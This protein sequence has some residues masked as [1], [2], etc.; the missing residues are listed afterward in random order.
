MVGDLCEGLGVTGKEDESLSK[1]SPGK[2]V[3]Q[4]SA[5]GASQAQAPTC[6]LV[7][8]QDVIPVGSPMRT[9]GFS[10]PELARPPCHLLLCHLVAELPWGLQD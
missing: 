2:G 6:L 1:G 4:A 8:S 3:L 5:S 9:W 10:G 7:S